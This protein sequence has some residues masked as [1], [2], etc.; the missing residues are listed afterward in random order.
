MSIP[1]INLKEQYRA[2]QP[3]TEDR[4]NRVLEHGHGS[5]LVS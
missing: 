3:Q 4:A 1:F 2:L 5:G